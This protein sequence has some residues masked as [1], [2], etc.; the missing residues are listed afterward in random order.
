ME[1]I[2]AEAEL[3]TQINISDHETQQILIKNQKNILVLMN[4]I[5]DLNKSYNDL[6]SKTKILIEENTELKKINREIEMDKNLYFF[7]MQHYKSELGISI[8][9]SDND[10]LTICD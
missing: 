5:S 3:L 1:Q 8:D 9:S 7:E 4:I 6:C 10:S 2:L